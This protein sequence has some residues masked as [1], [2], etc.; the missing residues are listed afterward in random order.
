[1]IKRNKVL[2]CMLTAV[3]G[4]SLAMPMTKA[5]AFTDEEYKT[6]LKDSVYFYDAN[7]CGKEVAKDNVFDWRGACHI[8]D[9]K[10]LNVDLTGGYHDAGDHVKFGLP[11]AYSA[12]VMG[13]ALYE[14]KDGFIKAGMY[15]KQI[16]QLKY[17]TDYFL[18]CHYAP[19]KFAYQVGD[20]NIDHDYWA[21]PE[22]QSDEQGGRSYIKVADS[23]SP[24]SDILGE[25]TAALSI[26][27]LNYKDIDSNYANKCLENAK[28]LFEMGKRTPGCSSGQSFYQSSSYNDDLAWGASWLYDAT[29]DEKY[30]NEAKQLL[31]KDSQWLETNWTM[32]W[33]DMKV[34]VELKLYQLTKDESYKK[35]VDYNMNYWEN[36]LQPKDGG[37]KIRDGWG[38]LRYSAAASM[39]ALIYN[40]SNPSS[41]LTDL[42]SSQINYILGDN[43]SGMSYMIGFGNKW[44][45]HAHHR[46]ANGY[47][48]NVETNYKILPN[49]YVLTGAL[50]GGPDGNGIFKDELDQYTYN[51]VAIDY[52]AGWVGA[53]AG[54]V[55]LNCTGTTKALLGDINSDGEIDVSDYTLFRKYF[56]NGQAKINQENA[57]VNQ[58]GTVNFF[59]LVALKSMI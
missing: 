57:D 25:V 54:Y 56:N 4:L 55:E 14:F 3:M 30:L 48:K 7:K 51:E 44:P 24:A 31:V 40:K 45:Q 20:G 27:Y 26:M 6:A 13:W 59:D 28:E 33:N 16:E 58:D 22:K 9:G 49:K 18:K 29:K 21:S 38:S 2:A 19:D 46:A 53:L 8:N 43:P 17:F 10:E 41:A 12:S 39:L 36:D 50:V 5:Y 35:A 32:C 15:N 52:N 23:S 42:A 34:P 37:I 11:Q 47:D 1:M